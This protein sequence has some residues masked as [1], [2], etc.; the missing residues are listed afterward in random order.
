MA[1]PVIF[2]SYW[3]L[4][5]LKAVLRQQLKAF[6]SV[7]RCHQY[8]NMLQKI[9]F[10]EYSVKLSLVFCCRTCPWLHVQHSGFTTLQHQK[11][12]LC[13]QCEQ[14]YP[15]YSRALNDQKALNQVYFGKNCSNQQKLRHWHRYKW[16]AMY[17]QQLFS[18]YN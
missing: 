3:Q 10:V 15:T 13:C 6:G 14:K 2:Y 11:E 17:L 5:N 9:Q 12:V 16:G 7:V 8:F 1:T 4:N 18:F